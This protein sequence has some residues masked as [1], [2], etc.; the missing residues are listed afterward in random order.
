[1]KK[2]KFKQLEFSKKVISKLNSEKIIGGKKASAEPPET[3]TW[4]PWGHEACG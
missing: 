2:I 1:M 4:C 3:F